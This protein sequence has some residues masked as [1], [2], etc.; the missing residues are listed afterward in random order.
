M[1]PA[2]ALPVVIVGGGAAGLLAAVFAARAGAPTVVVE[3]TRQG[4]KKIVVS[5]G[6]R[7]NVLPSAS[8]ERLFVTDSSPRLLGRILGSWPLDAQRRFFEDDLGVPLALEPETGKLFPASNRATDVRDALVEAATRA[9]ARFRFSTSVDAVT[10]S[11]APGGTAPGWRVALADGSALDAAAVVVATGGLSVPK[12]G[13]DGWGLA[14]ARATGHRVEPTYPALAPLT[15]APAPHADL[16]GVSVPRAQVRAPQGRGAFETSGGFLFTHRGYSGPAVLNVS[17]LTALAQARGADQPVVV[18][19]TD[20]APEAWD[21]ALREPGRGLVASALRAALPARLADHLQ[22]DAGVPADR[23][24]A[25]LR[26]DERR[27]LIEAL[28]AYPLPWTGDEGYKKAEVTGGGVGLGEVD[29]Q[30]LESRHQ[31]GLFFSGEV[32]D[33]FG[34]IGGYNF[35]WAWAT[36]RLAGLGAA[37]VAAASAAGLGGSGGEE[38]W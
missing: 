26:R 34:P 29:T 11:T 27:R 37:Q 21:Q 19:W 31:P 8:D 17:H 3:R 24:R 30:T 16:A 13:S 25:D 5:G 6:G 14:L 15:A 10:P 33:A 22:A 1:P 7:C 20:V 2:P 18:G 9:G 38:V 32:L 12:T 28:T 4:G 23:Q 35:Q 36:G